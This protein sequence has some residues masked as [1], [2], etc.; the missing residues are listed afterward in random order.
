MARGHA[1][2]RNQIRPSNRQMA[3]SKIGSGAID[4]Q[5]AAA[6][7]HLSQLLRSRASQR[8]R[9]VR[10]LPMCR[11]WGTPSS[12][13]AQMDATKKR[14]LYPDGILMWRDDGGRSA[15]A[16]LSAGRSER[17]PRQGEVRRHFDVRGPDIGPS[18]RH[19]LVHAK[20]ARTSDSS[21]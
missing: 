20:C 2:L 18:R 6:A 13:L 8:A 21:D 15:N 14:A 17:V 9:C 7:R 11:R 12:Q 19:K 3:T 4:R 5:S 10:E 1:D 16:E